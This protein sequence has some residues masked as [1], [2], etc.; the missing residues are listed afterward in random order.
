MGWWRAGDDV[1]GGPAPVHLSATDP[2]GDAAGGWTKIGDSMP[3]AAAGAGG[4]V[5]I[6]G[7]APEPG[8]GG[9]EQT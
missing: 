8:R 1:G 6:D 5:S 9:F 3:G 2:P 7:A 4:F